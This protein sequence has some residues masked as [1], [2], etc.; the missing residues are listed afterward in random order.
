MEGGMD[1]A[2]TELQLPHKLTLNERKSLTMTGVT[3]VVS[4]DENTV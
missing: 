4:F 3:E 2:E 1:M